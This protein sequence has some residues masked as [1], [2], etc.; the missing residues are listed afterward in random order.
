MAEQF[1]GSDSISEGMNLAKK[2]T[3]F[4]KNEMCIT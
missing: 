3:N 2:E 4:E 1:L